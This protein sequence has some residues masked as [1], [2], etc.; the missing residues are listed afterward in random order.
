[1]KT[2]LIAIS[3]ILGASLIASHAASA[4]PANGSPIA[5]ALTILDNT[6]AEPVACHRVCTWRGCWTRCSG[7]ALVAPLVVAP[8][9]HSV[10][11]CDWRGCFWRQRCY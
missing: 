8:A 5:K 11:I 7:P 1:M 9:C 10:R 6:K 2:I 4:A 3:L